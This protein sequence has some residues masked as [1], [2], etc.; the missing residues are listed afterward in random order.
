MSG[1]LGSAAYVKKGET[2]AVDLNQGSNTV[3]ASFYMPAGGYVRRLGVVSEAAAGL[4]APSVLNVA[5]STDGGAT[6]TSIGTLTSGARARAV[7]VYRNLEVAAAVVPANSLVA[8]RAQTAAGGTSTGRVWAEVQE[9][10]LA[11]TSIPT[12]AVRVTV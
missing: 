3:L 9:E 2:S 1:V 7:P 10:P 4:L 6:F 8:I 11:G 12:T 5:Y